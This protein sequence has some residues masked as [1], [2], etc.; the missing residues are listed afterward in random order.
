MNATDKNMVNK[1]SYVHT[2]ENCLAIKRTNQWHTEHGWFTDVMLSR[3]NMGRT[4]SKRV[5]RLWL[6]TN[7]K[8]R[9]EGLRVCKQERQLGNTQS[10]PKKKE[11]LRV[12]RT[13][14]MF[15]RR[16]GPAFSAS[17]S[18]QYG[19]PPDDRWSGYWT[20]GGLDA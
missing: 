15:L 2:V 7:D 13:K 8:D 11:K 1:L 20:S 18:I 19:H 4:Y 6:E 9:F 12:L 10:V 3:R 16:I 5:R 14:R 17:G